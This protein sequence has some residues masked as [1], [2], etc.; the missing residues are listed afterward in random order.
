MRQYFFVQFG[1]FDKK[2]LPELACI[3]RIWVIAVILLPFVRG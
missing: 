3:P 2:L 1:N